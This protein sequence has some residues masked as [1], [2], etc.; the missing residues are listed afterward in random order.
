MKE[1]ELILFET[2]IGHLEEDNRNLIT[3]KCDGNVEN[4]FLWSEHFSQ[5]QSG[6][7][8]VSPCLVIFV[9]EN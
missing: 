8:T 5:F 4:K 7:K 2:S 6:M 3:I 9:L 1:S